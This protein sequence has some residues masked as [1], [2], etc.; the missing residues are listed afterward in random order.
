MLRCM[1]CSS[2]QCPSASHGFDCGTFP[3]STFGSLDRTAE[4]IAYLKDRPYADQNLLRLKVLGGLIHFNV[5]TQDSH[6]NADKLLSRL[7]RNLD[8]P[9][10]VVVSFQWD[11]ASASSS[12]SGGQLKP[13]E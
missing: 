12:K 7:R 11:V 8:Q 6:P 10:Q 3:G 2:V 1:G 13:K 5:L 9:R 4:H